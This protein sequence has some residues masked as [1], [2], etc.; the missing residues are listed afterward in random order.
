LLFRYCVPAYFGRVELY[1]E[2][3]QIKI[4]VHKPQYCIWD[5]GFDDEFGRK[6]R[7]Q[8]VIEE[9]TLPQLKSAY[10]ELK[11]EKLDALEA[12]AKANSA[13]NNSNYNQQIG[14]SD[15]I[16]WYTNNS[17]IPVV[18]VLKSRFLSTGEDGEPTWFQ[19]DIL[20]NLYAE[21]C[22]PCDNLTKNSQGYLNPPF[23]DFIPEL[24]AG[25]NRSPVDRAMDLADRIKGE[26]GKKD[27]LINRIKGNVVTLFAN[28]FPEGANSMTIAQDIANGLL[29]MEGANIDDMTPG[30]KNN[31]LMKVENIGID[32]NSYQA[33]RESIEMDKN[34]IR[35]I[36]SIPRIAL[37]TQQSVVGKGVQEQTITQATYGVIPLYDGFA[38]FINNIVHAACEMRKNLILVTDSEDEEILRL[39]PREYEIFK[40]SKKWP[41]TDLNIYLDN[42]DAV[43][44]E[45]RARLMVLFER[46]LQNP[47]SFVDAEV[48]ADALKCQTNTEL[49][50]LLK[51]KKSVWEEKQ[52]AKAAA[53][54]Q[55]QMANQAMAIEGQK[56]ITASQ[57]QG[58]IANTALKGIQDMQKA[59]LEAS[60]EPEEEIPA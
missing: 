24:M 8:G 32:Y 6:Q 41:L 45:E 18:T 11:Q 58:K 42:K 59:G 7:Y 4:K 5:N 47:N 3:G 54:Q 19:T 50:N 14:F 26:E 27:L 9:F 57:N 22:K 44:E 16:V 21:R 15:N 23:I 46:E 38:Q 20:G 35:D 43:T 2:K 30:E 55:A 52:M 34:E 28:Q 31:F 1:T 17:N 49:R 12:Q 39:T 25:K 48:A 33:L 60:L 40:L 29:T 53:E 37:G 56:E 10:P 36:F 13:Y 51:Y